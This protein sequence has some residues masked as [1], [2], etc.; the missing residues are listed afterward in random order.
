MINTINQYQSLPFYAQKQ[1]GDNAHLCPIYSPTSRAPCFQ[2]QLTGTLSAGNVDAYLYDESG[3]IEALSGIEVH[4]FTNNQ[5]YI[6]YDGTPFSSPKTEGE[7]HISLTVGSVEYRSHPLCLRPV[8]NLQDWEPSITCNAYLEG[9]YKFDVEFDYDPGAPC[10]IH[11]S[12]DNVNWVR[13]GSGRPGAPASF[14]SDDYPGEEVFARFT[15]WLDNEAFQKIFKITFDLD[16]ID[17]CTTAQFTL[18]QTLGEALDKYMKFYWL[19]TKDLQNLNLMYAS[20]QSQFYMQEF[21][22]EV[23]ANLPGLVTEE[24][25][26]ENGAGG[27]VLD[28]VRIARRYQF[29]TY[30]VPDAA[31]RPLAVMAYHDVTGIAQCA[32]GDAYAAQTVTVEPSA[33]D[34]APCSTVQITMEINRVIVGCQDN[35]EEKA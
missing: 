11:F 2:V 7:Y 24:E 29:Q 23:Y 18:L 21:F 5:S 8:F 34:N 14:D 33:V 19:N 32:T 31:L 6:T 22:A 1:P 15:V 10:E 20:V 17:P 13:G 3:V 25:F 12:A 4:N 27:R 30:G 35:L 16:D 9:G 26:L 28:S